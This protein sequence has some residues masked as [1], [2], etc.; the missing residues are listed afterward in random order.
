MKCTVLIHKNPDRSKIKAL[1]AHIHHFSCA[2]SRCIRSSNSPCLHSPTCSTPASFCIETPRPY[3]HSEPNE[4]SSTTFPSKKISLP[5]RPPPDP[6]KSHCS[7]N[8]RKRSAW[9]NKIHCC[10]NRISWIPILPLLSF[11]PLSPCCECSR[12]RTRVLNP[13]N[14]MF[15]QLFPDDISS[16]N[17]FVTWYRE[18]VCWEIGDRGW[19]V[20]WVRRWKGGWGDDMRVWGVWESAAVAVADWFVEILL[21]V[22]VGDTW[23]LA[24]TR[25]D[26]PCSRMWSSAVYCSI[27]LIRC[28]QWCLKLVGGLH[29]GFWLTIRTSRFR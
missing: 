2:T 9:T 4:L 11:G 7:K 19:M 24:R 14:R 25:V 26:S 23:L 10:E 16:K 27:F 6:I 15:V 1:S 18:Y 29:D 20:V 28:S 12:S 22:F 21:L 17:A 13:S 8:P 5:P 3:L